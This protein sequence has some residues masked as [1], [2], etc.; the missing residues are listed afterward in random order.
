MPRKSS[1]DELQTI[2]CPS[3][4][5]QVNLRMPDFALELLQQFAPTRKS[6]G[7]TFTQLLVAEQA[8]REGRIEGRLEERQ[9][10]LDLYD[11]NGTQN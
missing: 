5:V 6:W 1:R 9:R 4:M 3:K 2:S 8:R 10:L 7:A 11:K